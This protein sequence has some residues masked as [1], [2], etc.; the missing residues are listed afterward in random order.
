MSSDRWVTGRETCFRGSLPGKGG[1]EDQVVSENENREEIETPQ[2]ETSLV[3]FMGRTF[4]Y[5]N[6]K[7]S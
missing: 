2:D 4:H 3:N 5:V 6:T 1:N 7:S